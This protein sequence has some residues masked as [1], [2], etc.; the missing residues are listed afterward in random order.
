MQQS[1]NQ[2][3]GHVTQLAGKKNCRSQAKWLVK[4]FCLKQLC[5]RCC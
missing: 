1:A 3:Q 2:L 4:Q 5:E